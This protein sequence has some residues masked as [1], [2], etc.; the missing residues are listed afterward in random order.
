[1][2]KIQTPYEFVREHHNSI[3]YNNHQSRYAAE[4][5]YDVARIQIKNNKSETTNHFL[6]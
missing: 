2:S 6:Q 1:M 5:F 3:N 4:P